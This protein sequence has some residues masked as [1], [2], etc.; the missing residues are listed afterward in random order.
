MFASCAARFAAR[1]ERPSC[2]ALS[3]SWQFAAVSGRGQLRSPSPLG[4]HPPFIWH[5]NCNA[6]PRFFIHACFH[7]PYKIDVMRRCRII[8]IGV[9]GYHED[10]NSSCRAHAII[11]AP[12]HLIFIEAFSFAY[13]LEGS[14]TRT[15]RPYTAFLAHGSS[16]DNT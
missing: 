3:E 1:R 7:A 4:S 15:R 2:A 9:S 8:L 14:E 13:P 16:S 11:P 10:A 5:G 12:E 6:A